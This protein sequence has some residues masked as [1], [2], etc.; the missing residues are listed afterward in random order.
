MTGTF[1]LDTNQEIG[2]AFPTIVCACNN[3]TKIEKRKTLCT[4]I[5]SINHVERVDCST[6]IDLSVAKLDIITTVGSRQPHLTLAMG[7]ELSPV[8]SSTISQIEFEISTHLKEIPAVETAF[9]KLPG[10]K[11]LL[12]LFS[13]MES[14]KYLTMKNQ[15]E[16]SALAT[17]DPYHYLVLEILIWKLPRHVAVAYAPEK[18]QEP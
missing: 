13:E 1:D 7:S 9:L 4:L 12:E 3:I 15:Y 10:T 6:K 16:G 5:I 2:C 8:F 18:E 11:I 14:P 17:I